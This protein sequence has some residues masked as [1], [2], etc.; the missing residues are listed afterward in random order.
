MKK[1]SKDQRWRW[2]CAGSLLLASL[3]GNL[4]ASGLSHPDVNP[5]E[6]SQ[7]VRKLRGTILDTNGTPVIGASISVKGTTTGTISD[8]NGVFTLDVKN[9]DIL[10]ISFIGY[11][12]HTVKVGT[13]TDLQV[14]LKEDTQ[15]LDEVVVVGYGVQKKSVMTAAISRVTSDDL[16]KLTPTRVED[17]LRGKVSG[18][19]IMQNSG[20]PGAESRVRIRGTGTINDS[21]PLYIVDGM[22][23]EGGVDYLNPQDIQSIEVLKDAAS[24]AIYGSR[25]ANGVILVTTKSGKKGKAVVNYDFSIGW[26]NP[27][28]KMS[29]LNATEYETIM[30]EAYVNAGMDP[31]YD[32]PSKA[33]VGTNWQN[34]IYNENA[35]I[36]NHQAS[37]SGG[38]DKGS[39][40]LSFGYLDQEGIVGGKDKSDYKRYSLRFNNTYNVFENKAN[41][42]FRSFKVGTNLGYTRI[43]SKGISENDNFSGP[44]ASAVMT[45]PN[46]SV[47]LENPSA[48]DLAYYEKNYPGYVKDD[49]GRIYN[50]IENQEIVN[51][52]AMMQTL[53]NNKDWDKFVGSVWGE[54]EVFENLTF[55]TSLSTDMAFWGER[56]WFPVSYLIIKISVMNKYIY[57]LAVVF[58]L[59]GCNDFLELSPTNKVIETDYYKT[60]EDLTEALVAAYDPLKW[61]AYNAYSS[62]ELVSNIMS[63]DAEIGGSTVSDQP[64]LQRVNDFTNWVT[65]TNLPEGLW[66]RSYEGVNRAN[67]VIEKCPLLPEG[68]MS[69]E[70]RDRYVAE[71]HFLRV[72]YYFQLWRFF[73]YIPYYETNLGLDDITTVP[74]LQPDEVYAKLIEDLDNNVIG[75]LPK[76]VPAN[77]KGRATNGA[78]IAMKARIVLYQND[79]TKM[80]EIASQLKELIT[81]PAYQ[82]DLIPDYK[83]LFDDEYEWCKESV[84]EVN[85]TEIG[86]SNDWAGKANQGNSDIIMLGARGLKDPNN[87][88]VEGWGFAPVTKALND[89]FLPND[90]RKWTTIIDHEEFRA[91]GGTVSSDVNQYT[92]YSVRKYHPRAG[93]SSTVGTEALNYKNNYRVIRFS[94]VLLM[95]SEALLRSGGS[96]GEA[97]DYYAR[98]VKRAMGDDYKV[99]VVSLDNIYKE[100]RYEFAMEGI[101]YWDL[102]RTNQAKDFI[103]G[104]DDTKKYLPIPQS[105]IDKSDG[106]LVQNPHF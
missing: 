102:V 78:A 47:Y 31:I 21:N 100:R 2:I 52:V 53:N 71:A 63:D 81:D 90:P 74:Q 35:P 92:G 104:W 6:V 14:V 88:Y 85:Y 33:G 97:Q 73:G 64:Q 60:Q 48:E 98:V 11:L 57:L 94:D 96:V 15:A 69:E 34:E 4:E 58:G 72:F 67:I 70:L 54:L 56:N 91:E 101:R 17:V 50:V 80:K 55:K 46:E 105:E 7:T 59:S 51:P 23:L 16:E 42:F 5:M 43:I 1:K 25:A 95:A 61:N 89:A 87:V 24:A 62:Y 79:D 93:Y 19:S 103:K 36:M 86:N 20:Q 75:K 12:S 40:F 22:P 30:N 28:R 26:Q 68:T 77:E 32:D 45:P 29:V 65:P 84:F 82:Y 99:P 18:V 39:Y 8:M 3:S 106:H 13:Q 76:I 83:V 49:E 10:E 9:G 38:G 37:I 66:G 27:W 44:L 41:K